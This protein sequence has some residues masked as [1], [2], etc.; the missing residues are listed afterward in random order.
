MGQM[1]RVPAR[2]GCGARRFAVF[3]CEELAIFD[4]AALQHNLDAAGV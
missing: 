3:H 4:F 2:D 1:V